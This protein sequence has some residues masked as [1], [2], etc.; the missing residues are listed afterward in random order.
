[1]VCASAVDAMLKAKEYTDGR[2]YT[3]IDKAADDH[4]LTPEMAKWAHQV[5]LDANEQRHADEQAPLP[6]TED[7]RRAIDFAKALAELLFVLP[8]RVQRG[9]VEASAPAS[10]GSTPQ[11]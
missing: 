8:A 10:E 7:A 1:M 2:L 6:S 9:I 4:L 3:R 11:P 5:R